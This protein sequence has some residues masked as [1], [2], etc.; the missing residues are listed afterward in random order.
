MVVTN[1]LRQFNIIPPSD[2]N[3]K[4]AVRDMITDIAK[5][6]STEANYIRNGEVMTNEDLYVLEDC[7]NK[8]IKL[9]K[10]INEL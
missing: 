3:V 7:V 2:K 6:I 1:I 10:I 5:D 4:S 9:R 8:L